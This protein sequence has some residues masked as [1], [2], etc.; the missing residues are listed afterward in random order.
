[1]IFRCGSNPS[2]LTYY[3][4]SVAESI[5]SCLVQLYAI[6][7]L[8]GVSINEPSV[9]SII[10]SIA[11][12][13]L[14]STTMC[15][16]FDLD[17]E[18]RMH[19]SDFY[20]YVPNSSGRRT[21]VFYSIFFF[22]SCH[23][24][25]R[26]LGIAL[27]ASVSPLITAAVLGADML[28]FMLF[29]L[30]RSDLRY[31]VKLPGALSWIASILFRI[32][33]KIMVDFTV[34]VQLRHPQEIGGMYWCVCL[35]LGQATSFVAAHLYYSKIEGALEGVAMPTFALW[36]LLCGL[37]AAFFFFFVTFVVASERKYARTFVSTMT[38]SQYRIKSFREAKTDQTK[39][40]VIK[41]H[42]SY[43]ASI[44]GEVAE[45]VRE[46]WDVWNEERPHWFTE[47]VRGGV[48]KDMIPLREDERKREDARIEL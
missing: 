29:K 31:W 33:T 45:W 46:N 7:V 32:V 21:V 19:N 2:I 4:L 8:P 9:V 15:F 11:T 35:L 47:R 17:P 6:L 34:M 36:G 24:A 14:G 38:A 1:M 13:S 41:L 12:I 40:S 16:D 10:F 25:L 22:T 3:F 26:L 27:L 5:P 42:P 18:R 23:V 28:A 39:M 44:R 37:E 43:Y 20:G 48:P 30:A